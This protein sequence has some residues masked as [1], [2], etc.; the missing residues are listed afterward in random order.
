VSLE[1]GDC[2]IAECRALGYGPDADGI[3]IGYGRQPVTV[4][5]PDSA[6]K[7]PEDA[8]FG[9]GLCIPD[10]CSIVLGTGRKPASR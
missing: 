1:N 5:R 10:A 6:D 4:G 2:R 9:A 3:V 7:P 8:G